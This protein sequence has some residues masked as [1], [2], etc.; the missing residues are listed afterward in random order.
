MKNK[1][2][3]ELSPPFEMSPIKYSRESTDRVDMQKSVETNISN[4]S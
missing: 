3:T 4:M 2:Q 1:F